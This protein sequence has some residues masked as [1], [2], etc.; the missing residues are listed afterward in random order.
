MHTVWSSSPT[1]CEQMRSGSRN[2]PGWDSQHTPAIKAKPRQAPSMSWAYRVEHPEFGTI[3]NALSRAEYD[4]LF[5]ALFH[6]TLFDLHDQFAF[7]VLPSVHPLHGHPDLIGTITPSHQGT[8]AIARDLG[9]MSSHP[10]TFMPSAIDPEDGHWVARPLLGDFMLFLFDDQGPYCLHFDIKHEEGAHDK[11]GPD[12]VAS[13]QGDRSKS[14]A[15]AKFR[16]KAQYLAEVGIRVVYLHPGQVDLEVARNLRFL[17][18]WTVRS[19]K[20]GADQQDQLIGLLQRAIEDGTP[21][22]MV[23][24]TCAAKYGW[25]PEECRRVLFQAIWTKRLRVDLFDAILIDQPLY[26]ETRDVIDEYAHWF[27]R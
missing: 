14:N 13:R 10:K 24:S 11:P 19:S 6:P 27:V 15:S 3:I 21:P 1:K 22:A 17:F 2:A 7:D 18:A 9:V 16:I 4:L 20:L 26:P 23:I 5:V 25:S 12:V 8:L